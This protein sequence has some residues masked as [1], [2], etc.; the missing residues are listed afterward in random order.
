MFYVATRFQLLFTWSMLWCVCMPARK[1][2]CF[3]KSE[4]TAG[5]P[6][7]CCEWEFFVDGEWVQVPGLTVHEHRDSKTSNLTGDTS[8]TNT[9]LPSHAHQDKC[10]KH[11]AQ[12]SAQG[13]NHDPPATLFGQE[14]AQSSPP[15]I[16]AGEVQVTEL[17]MYPIKSCAGLRI[18]SSWPFHPTR[19]FVHDRRWVRA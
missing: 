10:K 1:G 18:Q 7:E 11:P 9:K 13:K 3:G 6:F 15:A 16:P 19:G 17:W 4:L 12:G 5:M 8:S 14:E 2:S